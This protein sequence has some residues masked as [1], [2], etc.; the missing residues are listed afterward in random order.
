MTDYERIDLKEYIGERFEALNVRLDGFEHRLD[1]LETAAD[2]RD[3][4][5]NFVV[6][7]AKAFGGLIAAILAALG[8]KSQIGL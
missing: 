1:R 5:N 8:I 4:R 7:T 2:Q 3:G 6:N